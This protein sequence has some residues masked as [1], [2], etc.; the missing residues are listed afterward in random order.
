MLVSTIAA[1]AVLAGQ[2]SAN[3]MMSMNMQFLALQ[4]RMPGFAL[5][6]MPG[7]TFHT[8]PIEAKEDRT[9]AQFGKTFRFDSKGL[10][11]FVMPYRASMRQPT[12]GIRPREFSGF[13]Y[14]EIKWIVKRPGPEALWASL[15]PQLPPTGPI[16]ETGDIEIGKDTDDDIT[17]DNQGGGTVIIVVDKSVN[18]NCKKCIPERK[19][20]GRGGTYQ[21]MSGEEFGGFMLAS[22]GQQLKGSA[23][24][25]AGEVR[26]RYAEPVRKTPTQIEAMIRSHPDFNTS[27]LTAA[28]VKNLASEASKNLGQGMAMTIAL[29]VSCPQLGWNGKWIIAGQKVTGSQTMKMA[30]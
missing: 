2:G 17:V 7:R 5:A 15:T 24:P 4:A 8:G 25:A 1:T 11:S 3:Q 13:T 18:I 23:R 22:N 30:R 28:E 21:A 14:Q 9:S 26:L 29:K 6:Q 16:V 10:A 12:G 19:L 27:R 20:P